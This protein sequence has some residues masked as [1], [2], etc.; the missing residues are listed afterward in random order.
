[1]AGSVPRPRPLVARRAGWG[2]ALGPGRGGWRRP[3]PRA[4]ALSRLQLARHGQPAARNS[5]DGDRAVPLLCRC[6]ERWGTRRLPATRVA[7]GARDEEPWGGGRA[8]VGEPPPRAAREFVV[9][10][11]GV[12]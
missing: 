8:Q 2:A 10:A 11:R 12:W 5:G 9:A 6:G 1:L 3:R 4:R 7:G